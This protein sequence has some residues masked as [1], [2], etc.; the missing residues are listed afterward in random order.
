[1]MMQIQRLKDNVCKKQSGNKHLY[2]YQLFTYVSGEHDISFL[3][4]FYLEGDQTLNED[5]SAAVLQ[6]KSS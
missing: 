3:F 2:I 5:A 1:M 6:V 4:L